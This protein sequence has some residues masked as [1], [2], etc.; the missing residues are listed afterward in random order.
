MDIQQILI[1]AFTPFVKAYWWIIPLLLVLYF[2][3]TSFMKGV[4]GELCL[5]YTSPSPRD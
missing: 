5:L 2:F 1:N 4:L 3:K